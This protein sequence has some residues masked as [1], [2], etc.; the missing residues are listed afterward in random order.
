[1]A[2]LTARMFSC[3]LRDASMARFSSLRASARSA[4]RVSSAMRASSSCVFSL[5]SASWRI[6]SRFCSMSATM[7]SRFACFSACFSSSFFLRV[8]IMRSFC[9]ANSAILMSCSRSFCFS[10]SRNCRSA[11]FALIVAMFASLARS[12]RSSS[13][14]CWM[15]TSSC[16]FAFSCRPSRR[17]IS[18]SSRMRVL[19]SSSC[20]SCASRSSSARVRRSSNLRCSAASAISSASFCFCTKAASCFFLMSTR[21]R[22]YSI[23]FSRSASTSESSRDEWN[24]FTLSV[25]S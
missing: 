5:A 4:S 15:R 20:S 7:R 19:R 11:S 8:T 21:E 24:A 9:L 18:L 25:S 17:L 1:M 2:R 16:A 22:A 14:C 6:S 13:F 12:R 10:T 23:C 3:W